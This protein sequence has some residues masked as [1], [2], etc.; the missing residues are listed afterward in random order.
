MC[1]C[2]TFFSTVEF[3]AKKFPPRRI[4]LHKLAESSDGASSDPP[5][6]S[7][8]ADTAGGRTLHI[9]TNATPRQTDSAAGEEWSVV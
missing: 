1:V 8:N 7:E 2:T 5:P 9:G 4:F 6:N 3:T